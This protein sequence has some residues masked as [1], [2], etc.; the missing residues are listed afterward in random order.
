VISF[1]FLV[2]LS[3][4][5]DFSLSD[6]ERGSD[7]LDNPRFFFVEQLELSMFG[8]GWCARNL[9][10][11]LELW[12]KLASL[13]RNLQKMKIATRSGKKHGLVT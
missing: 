3:D 7:L 1:F 12:M 8:G 10:G 13:W 2:V 5:G 6:K 11:L 4:N 9:E